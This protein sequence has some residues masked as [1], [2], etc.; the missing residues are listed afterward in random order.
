MFVCG[1]GHWM[2]TA[3]VEECQRDG[4]E[5]WLVRSECRACG[6][7]VAVEGA[8][9][10]TEPFVDR[11][12]WSDEARHTFDRMPPYVQLLLGPEVEQYACATDHRVISL[13][14]LEE[15][16]RGRSISWDPEA[17]RRLSNVPAA[18]RAMARVELERTALERGA[19]EVTIAL[20]EEVKARYFGMSGAG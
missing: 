12:I 18:V 4:N 14:T 17:E 20:M 11:L 13:A 2:H 16:R 8:P 6:W 9:K 1:C 19:P 5:T 10:Q 3:G 7:Q 15:A